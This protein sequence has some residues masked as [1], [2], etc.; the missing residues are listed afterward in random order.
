MSE[1]RKRCVI[2][3]K[4]VVAATYKV[5]KTVEADDV[6]SAIR[7]VENMDFTLADFD[8]SELAV[9]SAKESEE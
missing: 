7:K 9:M 3:M 5:Y 4:Y 6:N 2:D 1:R 8:K